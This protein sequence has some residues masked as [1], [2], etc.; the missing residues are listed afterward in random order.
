MDIFFQDPTAIPLPPDEVRIRGLRLELA[1][2][3]RRVRVLLELTPFQKRPNGEVII[4]NPKGDE[5]ASVNII[6]SIVPRMEFT[7]H[8]RGELPA[9]DYQLNAT[10]YYE[11]EPEDPAEP[12][13]RGKRIVVDLAKRD[14][15]IGDSTG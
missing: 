6:E 15:S 10:L 11:S 9:G 7:M 2:D 12:P 8:M 1:P 14:F 13:G 5:V 4:T 3:Q